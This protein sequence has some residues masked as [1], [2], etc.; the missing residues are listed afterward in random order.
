MYYKVRF[1]T[2]Q[3]T[4]ERTT[5]ALGKGLSYTRVSAGCSHSARTTRVV[6]IFCV[7]GDIP[8]N[9]VDESPDGHKDVPNEFLCL[10]SQE[11]MRVTIWRMPA[12]TAPLRPLLMNELI[13]MKSC[14]AA[15]SILDSARRVG[16][17]IHVGQ[18]TSR[19]KHPK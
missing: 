9:G 13:F 14:S 1:C 6:A 18:P 11:V 19:I 17:E 12:V 5:P 10:I 2:C 8:D 15:R 4:C 3:G 16:D 7:G